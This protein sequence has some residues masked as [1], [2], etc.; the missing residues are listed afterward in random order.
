MPVET[1]RT[2]IFREIQCLRQWWIWVIFLAVAGIM[3]YIFVGQ[4]ILGT[5]MGSR[6][7]PD[8]A[9]WLLW[10]FV[11]IG[12]PSF[13]WSCRMTTEVR[14]DQLVMIWAPFYRRKFAY[15]DIASCE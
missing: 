12:F 3:W 5:P 7:A 4:I 9:V 11:G 14:D 10:I 15:S 1:A 2:P 13:F 6:P 8:A